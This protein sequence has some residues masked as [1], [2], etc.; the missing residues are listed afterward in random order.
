MS[1]VAPDP[2]RA[3]PPCPDDFNFL[4][5]LE[6]PVEGTSQSSKWIEHHQ[7]SYFR[8]GYSKHQALPNNG[9]SVVEF[10][11]VQINPAD[12]INFLVVDVDRCDALMLLMHPAVPP[13]TWIIH[14]PENG[15]AQAGW[16]IDSVYIGRGHTPGPKWY[17]EAV[18]RSLTRLVRGD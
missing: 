11:Y 2:H 16:A 5:G 7:L 1:R 9:Q 14:K 4:L 15:H 18:L 6:S 3:I 8:A 17:A 12:N 10:P 13:A